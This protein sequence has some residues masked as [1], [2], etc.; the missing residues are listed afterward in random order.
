MLVQVIQRVIFEEPP[1]LAPFGV[2]AYVAAA[3]QRGMAKDPAERPATAEDFA[4]EL[5]AAGD[6][7]RAE[8]GVEIP[9]TTPALAP[10]P[11]TAV[12]PASA[13]ALRTVAL[14]RTADAGRDA[15]AEHPALAPDRGSWRA[16]LHPRR[17]PLVPAVLLGVDLVAI[18]GWL[19]LG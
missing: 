14:T 18:G 5:R 4:V 13:E 1:D 9:V 2:P 19:V 10:A 17:S 12:A 16:R 15:G 8:T 7:A 11:A 6:Q 3:I